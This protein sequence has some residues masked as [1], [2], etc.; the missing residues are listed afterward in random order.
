MDFAPDV[1]DEFIRDVVSKKVYSI[2]VN[3]SKTVGRDST[4]TKTPTPTFQIGD[5]QRYTHEGH[6]DMV[7]LVD[8]NTND[9]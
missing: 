6:N 1:G 5:S 8:I 3:S 4:Q 7:D 2:L 9:N